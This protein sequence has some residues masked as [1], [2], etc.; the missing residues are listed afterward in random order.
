[1]GLVQP[2]LT[3][4]GK[5]GRPLR[6]DPQRIFNGCLYITRESCC[7][8]SLPKDA[9]PPWSVVFSHFQRWSKSG[10]FEQAAHAL[11]AAVRV[12][13]GREETPSTLIIDVHSRKSRNG[14]EDIGFD[15]NK[16]VHGRKNQILIDPLGLVWGVRTHA[17]N[18]SDTYEAVPLF[19]RFLPLFPRAKRVYCDKG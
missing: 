9:Y 2:I 3:R 12:K 18:L 15:G 5:P 16:K 7:W 19:K 4:V 11:N 1:M 8:R 10:L 13:A 6:Y 17:A 14:G